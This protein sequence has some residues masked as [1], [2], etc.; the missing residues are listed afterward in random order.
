MAQN[1]LTIGPAHTILQNVSHAMPARR[2]I[3][4]S[5]G[6]LESSV[7]ESAWAAVTLT[8]NQ[9]ESGAPFIRTTAASA[10]IRLSAV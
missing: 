10:I 3:I 2:C 1:S 4:R 9:Y 5:D 8:N 7:D 6:A